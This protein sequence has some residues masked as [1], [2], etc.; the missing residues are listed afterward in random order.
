MQVEGVEDGDRAW[1][2]GW[3]GAS[4]PALPAPP[5]FSSAERTSFASQIHS[6]PVKRTARHR[7]P[8]GHDL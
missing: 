4:L 5:P 7:D 6:Q 2:S 1:W 8:E 3:S